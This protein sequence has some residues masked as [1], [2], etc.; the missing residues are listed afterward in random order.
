MAG[1]REIDGR[2]RIFGGGV[3]VA[4]RQ[5]GT[6]TG[7]RA[8]NIVDGGAPFYRSYTTKDGKYVAVG[9]IEPHF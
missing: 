7:K 1:P 8:D 3:P 6:W 2:R 5:Q 9:A 4:F